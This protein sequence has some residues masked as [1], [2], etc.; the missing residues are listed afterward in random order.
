MGIVKAHKLAMTPAWE[1]DLMATGPVE[2][3]EDC[4]QKFQHALA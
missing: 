3:M 2:D 4:E 1:N